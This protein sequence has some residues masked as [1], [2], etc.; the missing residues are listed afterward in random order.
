VFPRPNEFL[1][2]FQRPGQQVILYAFRGRVA[3]E[4]QYRTR[5]RRST[6][7]AA[8]AVTSFRARRPIVT[9]LSVRRRR[10]RRDRVRARRTMR[11]SAF[12]AL[13]RGKKNERTI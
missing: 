7:A 11:A 9:S 2:F 6:A 4:D 5:A 8:A 3:R 10:R 13:K 1:F 12:R